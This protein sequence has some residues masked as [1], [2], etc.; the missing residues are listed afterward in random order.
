MCEGQ[1]ETRLF[2]PE[3]KKNTCENGG[4]CVQTSYP[5]SN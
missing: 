2:T 5:I 1:C 3:K 4:I